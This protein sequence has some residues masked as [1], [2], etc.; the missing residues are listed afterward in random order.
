MFFSTLKIFSF[1]RKLN[2]IIF[3]EI[4]VVIRK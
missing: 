2:L 3:L 4:K 1:E